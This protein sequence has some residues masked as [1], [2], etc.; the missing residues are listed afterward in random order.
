MAIVNSRDVD[1]DL[2]RA[3]T[4]IMTTTKSS[5]ILLAV[6]VTAL[7]AAC[8]RAP[9]APALTRNRQL[10]S[11]AQ[12]VRW[13]APT[14]TTVMMLANEYLS[15]HR[16]REG[17]R[18]FDELAG[19]VPDRPLFL[20]LAGVFQAR[21]A[22]EQPL[23][24]RVSWVE[25]AVAR[26]DRAAAAGGPLERYLRGVV[27]AELPERFGRARQAV[28][29]LE[30]T[31]ASSHQLPPGFRRGVWH[32]LAAA[33]TTVGREADAERARAVAGP[34]PAAIV[35]SGSVNGSDGFRF[36]PRRVVIYPGGIFVATGYDFADIAFV[37]VEDG[38]VAIDAGT[39]EATARDALAAVRE[40]T[41][42]PIR[43]VIVTHAHWDHIGGLAAYAGPGVEVIAQARFSEQLAIVNRVAAPFRYF[44]GD[45][46]S[47]RFAMEPTRTVAA[48]ETITLGGRRFGIH[49]TRGG[50]TE[51][52]LLIHVPD[53][54]VLFVGD[55]FM[56][57][58]G[59]P[60]VA[61]G[62][63]DGLIDTIA[64]IR[65]LSAGTIIH[66]H[67][68]LTV[69]FTARTMAPLA[70]ALTALR[71]RTATGVRAGRELADLLA[72][73]VLPDSLAAHP[74]AVVPFLLLRD[75]FIKRYHH[76]GTGYWKTDGE[77]MEV[78]TRTE[79]GRALDLIAGGDES[80]FT[81][82]ARSL[83]DRGD[84]AMALRIAELGLAAHPQSAALAAE[85]RRALDGLRAQ[86][87]LDPFKF[88]IYS[89]MAG[90]TTPAVPPAHGDARAPVA[91]V[92]HRP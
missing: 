6:L 90:K 92:A 88:I 82:A 50:E 33:Y 46:V 29:D 5:S 85:R 18:Y 14:P 10:E 57:Y 28:I 26:L 36:T 66:G 39:T 20:A 21:I 23:L 62:S 53:A 61:E 75:N 9:V 79:W 52:A 19:K 42:A 49:P 43:A 25:A 64:Q 37:T 34:E 56:P 13:P 22:A 60:F 40:H 48:S 24:R 58:F 74:D 91:P 84:Y 87:Q 32:G 54:D 80:R 17:F 12:A 76:Q 67:E 38:L 31:L 2:L 45:K 89:E 30:A 8:A 41:R 1:I 68:P 51:D 77:G 70:S 35:T 65:A 11:L 78:F 47:G 69:N 16:E 72:E 4:P 27:F 81:D 63:P 15:T 83:D 3:Y 59:A 7:V 44:F 73:N 86:Y 71:T 55:A